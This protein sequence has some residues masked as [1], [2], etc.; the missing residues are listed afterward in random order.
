MNVVRFALRSLVLVL[1]LSFLTSFLTAAA[2]AQEG[3]RVAV[4]SGT[5][6]GE[7]I[8]RRDTELHVFRGI[9]FAAAP[10]RDLRWRPPQPVAAWEGERECIEFAA[11]CLQPADLAYA[12][13]Y[14]KQSEDCLYLNVWTSTLD[15]ERKLPVMVWIH[16]G[17]NAIGG[18]SAPTYDGATLA[19]AGVVLVSIQYRLGVLGFFAHPALSAENAANGGAATSGNQGLLD[20]IAALGW[21]QRNIA[22]FGGDPECVTIFGESAGGVDVTLLMSSPL[23]KGL[24]HR[25]VAMSGGY[26]EFMP[27]LTTAAGADHPA[28]YAS[29][30]EIGKR[31]DIDGEDAV[32]LAALR[33]LDAD[34]IRSIPLSIG[35][36]GGDRRGERALRLGPIVDGHVIPKSPEQ[37]WRDGEMH[38]VP[39]LTGSLRDDG[40][41]FSRASPIRGAM[42]YRLALRTLFGARARDVAELFPVDGEESVT[43]AVHRLVT[44]MSFVAPSR[45]MARQV[46]A[47]GGDAWLYHF[48]HEPSWLPGTRSVIHGIEL[49]F[50]FGTLPARASVLDR[51][52]A[53]QLRRHILVFARDGAP[54]V[55][56]SNQPG[57]DGESEAEAAVWPK[58]DRAGDTWLV[59][60][61][62]ARIQ[63]GLFVR[64]CDLFDAIAAS[65]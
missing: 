49:P 32:A 7:T 37:I 14:P 21:V 56:E 59:Y 24:F 65:R 36:I 33:A 11:A 30:K 42:A 40:S 6:R 2:A 55:V 39:F 23:A 29:S 4:D 10:V 19:A 54:G 27:G 47:A 63:T 44:L 60:D 16:G 8:V 15:R 43:A 26:H 9:P 57:H 28:A 52:L 45:R 53:T 48:A 1:S 35:N 31:F 17:G 46:A 20:Q 25:A 51:E 3:P 64:E 5:I 12:H 38:R 61:R 50:L 13:T 18:A 58:H 22:Q 62:G 34:A 41:V